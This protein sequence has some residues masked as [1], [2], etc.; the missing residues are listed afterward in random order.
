MP[1]YDYKCDECLNSFEKMVTVAERELQMCPECLTMAPMRIKSPPRLSSKMGLDPDFPTAHA[2]WGKRRE[3]LQ[4]GKM[5]DT[6][7]Q[8][9]THDWEKDQHA[10]KKR[11]EKR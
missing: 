10:A 1:I 4:T 5:K 7:N 11:A 3:Q 2:A 9:L 8:T 6:S